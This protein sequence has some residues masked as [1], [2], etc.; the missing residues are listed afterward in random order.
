MTFVYPDIFLSAARHGSATDEEIAKVDRE[1]L[2]TFLRTEPDFFPG[3]AEKTR[4]IAYE[5]RVV[6]W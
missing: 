1:P 6:R 3:R 5:A 2:I 4:L